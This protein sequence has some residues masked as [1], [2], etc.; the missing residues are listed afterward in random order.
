MQLW[1]ST[2]PIP[3]FSLRAKL[4]SFLWRIIVKLHYSRLDASQSRLRLSR[5]RIVHFTDDDDLIA[6]DWLS[7]LPSA[8][9]HLVF[10]RWTSVRYDGCFEFR[11]NSF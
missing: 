4:K 7:N 9:Q 10:C 11:S 2:M 6:P 8:D 1:D 5:F 3:F